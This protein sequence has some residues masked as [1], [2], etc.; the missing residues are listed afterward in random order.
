MQ[1]KI[2]FLA[3]TI[4]LLLS[5]T[6]Q[7]NAICP[8]GDLNSD[9]TINFLDVQLFG[10]QWLDSSCSGPSCADFDGIAGV[11]LTDYSMLTKNWAKTGIQ[12]AINEFLASNTSVNQDGAGDNDDWVEIYNYSDTPIDIGG[13]YL[14]D[15]L[16]NPTKW[17]VPTGDP[18]ATTID[19][20]DFLLIWTD[21][22]PGEG[23]LHATF[24]ISKDNDTELGLFDTDGITSIDTMT[25]GQQYTDISYGR[26][27][28]ASTE[29]RFF[30]VP[31]P[32]QSNNNAYLGVVEDTKF[33]KDRGFYTSPINVGIHT[34]TDGASIYYTLNGEEPTKSDTLYTTPL[35]ISSTTTL[36]VRAFK[37]GWMTTNIDT[38]TYIFLADVLTQSATAPG[39]GWPTATP[40]GGLDDLHMDYGM[41]PDVLTDPRYTGL[42]DDA[43]L[44][45]PS[46]SLV[47]DLDYLF[48]SSTG[49]YVNPQQ[50]G[51]A[52]ERPTSVELINPDGSKG[53]H[54]NA[55]LRI[56]GG[57]SRHKSNPK[58]A[59]RLFF[60]SEYGDSKLYFPL[61]GNEGADE[62]EKVDLRTSQNYSW[63]F[64]DWEGYNNTLVKDVFGRDMQ[65][66]MGQPYTRSRYYHL[67]LNGQYWGI[68]QTQERSEARYAETYFGGDSDDYDV[69]KAA[70]SSLD[71][72][73][74][75][76]TAYNNF[77]ALANAGFSSNAAYYQA[78]GLNTDGTENPAYPKYLD[79]DNVIDYMICTYYSGDFDGPISWFGSND[80]L[81]NFYAVYNRNNPDG[82]KF[83]RHDGEHTLLAH[84]GNF[85]QSIDRTGPYSVGGSSA[86]F[87]NPQWLHQQLTA[88]SEYRMRFA[89]RVHKHFF[90]D[91]IAQQTQA[92]ALFN[93]RKNQIDMAI[94]AESARWGD[95]KA[96]TPRTKD[97]D[98]L[99]AING[100]INNFFPTRTSVVTAQLRGQGW[101]PTIDPP[102]YNQHGGHVSPGFNLTM[103]NPNGSGTIYYTLDGNDPL[104]SSASSQTVTLITENAQKK[105][106]VPTATVIGS[107]SSILREYWDS[108]TGTSV[109]DLTSNGNYPDNPTF[110]NHINT[111]EAPTDFDDDYGTRIHGFVHPPTTGS[112]TFWIASDDNSELWLSSN[113]D[114]SNKSLIA[115]VDSWT[116]PRE[117]DK[118]GSQQSS[119]ISLTTGLRYYIEAIQKED[120]GGDNL[121]VAWQGP[122]ISRDVIDGQYLSP[123]GAAWTAT[124]FNDST[125]TSGTGGVGYED[126]SG[127]ESYFNIDVGSQ[128]SGT[129]PTCYIRIPFT[130]TGTSFQDLTLKMRYDDGFIVYL[131]GS[132]ILRV[133]FDTNTEPLWSSEANALNDDAAA[134]IFEDFD[135]TSHIG[136]LNSG[137]NVLAIHG[138]NDNTGSSDFL[139]SAKLEATEVSSTGISPTAIEY[140]G[141]VTLNKSTQVKARVLD[142]SEWSALNETVFAIGPVAENLRITELMYHPQDTN[143]PN[144]EYIEL[145]NIGSS[146]LNLN[147]VK[148]TNGVY[149]TFPDMSLAAG[150]YVLVVKDQTA[151]EAQY[152]AGYNIAGQYSGSLSNG[153]EEID[154]DDAVDTEILDFDYKDGWRD[155]T[156]GDGFSLTIIDPC[157]PDVNSWDEKNSWRASAYNGGSPD[158]GD[159][160]IIPNPGDIVVSEVLAHAD[161]IA[162]DWIELENT[163]SS[164]IDISGWFLSDNDSNL[165]KHEIAPG[166]TI[167]ANGYIVFYQNTHFSE[168]GLSENGEE[169][170]LSS[171][172]GGTLTGFR[173]KED[174]GASD[175]DIAFGRHQKSDGS[176]N[177]VA[178]SSNTAGFANAYP[179]VD[180]VVINEIMYNP[181]SGDQDEEY[182]E[183][184]N[185][186][187]APVTLY[188]AVTFESWKFTNGIDYTFPPATTIPANSYLMVAKDPTA[189]TAKYGAMP[190]GVQVLG[191]YTNKLNNKGEK[192]E[193]AM[194]GD[195]DGMGQRQYIRIDRV[196][197]D[198]KAPW[199]TGPDANGNYSLTRKISSNYGNDV[200]NWKQATPSP[201]ALNP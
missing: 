149:F 91:G 33:S 182:I 127:Y 17:M 172:D 135:I 23:T 66:I 136:L 170:C 16:S 191:P 112:Y 151:F 120:G 78:Q 167:P 58:H 45:I 40:P 75:N 113:D 44:A 81:N 128:M 110:I 29:L 134:I 85:T 4:L 71:P 148:F 131:N 200:D 184:Y 55:G 160:G 177:F 11:N 125:W 195:I 109:S 73:D 82:W 189:F 61:F 46:I 59:F 12:L 108:I 89:D 30:A 198:N 34:D 104:I 86:N 26:Y 32:E 77:W 8:I 94:I 133:N 84:D 38:H 158:T 76:T 187:G 2:I 21:D 57:W 117:W 147:L 175:A 96:A 18:A 192:L 99:P 156:D 50:D 169:V 64:K 188:D 140:T 27:P 154:L 1:F 67:Y 166:T 88:N 196:N 14:T 90:N 138:L 155:I 9:C 129:N 37:P 79:V 87:F 100:V 124:D 6:V 19:P 70:W 35:A 97:D 24:K 159:D 52:W 161:I 145:K 123:A 186:T 141:P 47:T 181:I 101:Y 194:P 142:G 115:S 201:G 15:N 114:P 51:V 42:V 63:S 72:T 43:L 95:A 164:I 132:E 53:F 106:L 80:Y 171:A 5:F 185:T 122:S 22:E 157:N 74:G 41:D 179:L 20:N 137:N 10:A 111:F 199:P 183:L 102:V 119:S 173:K 144:E 121:A 193:L 31:S 36:R 68:F 126:S 105:V 48:D 83:F 163:T 180:P 13:M 178:M 65:G 62:F 92:E 150:D 165:Q 174:F 197:Y 130:L 103:T 190:P 153:G 146:S 28:D 168:F 98:W 54:I 56:R 93:K 143:D 139:I 162:F 176:H 25:F 118:D 116:S 39:P 152:G 60:R 49:I 107:T 7:T 3:L 69:L